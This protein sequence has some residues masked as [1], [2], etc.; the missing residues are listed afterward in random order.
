MTVE[1]DIRAL[2]L[3]V[4]QILRSAG[5]PSI[6]CSGRVD[7]APRDSAHFFVFGIAIRVG[8]FRH[9]VR[10]FREDVSATE[11]AGKFAGWLYEHRET[12]SMPTPF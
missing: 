4:Q 5:F 9:G 10:F 11:I 12:S 3:S 1:Q 2:A 8:E 6:Q 7:L